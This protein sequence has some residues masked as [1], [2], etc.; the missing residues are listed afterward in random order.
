MKL[1][2]KAAQQ[3]KEKKTAKANGKFANA[4]GIADDA[5]EEVT[6]KITTMLTDGEESII[7]VKDIQHRY[8]ETTVTETTKVDGDICTKTT[9]TASHSEAGPVSIQVTEPSSKCIKGTCRKRKT[10]KTEETKPAE[11]AEE[12]T[13]RQR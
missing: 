4:K 10:P 9:T 5:G 11:H 1:D 2:K 8:P 12:L 13:P 3:L 6:K 7:N